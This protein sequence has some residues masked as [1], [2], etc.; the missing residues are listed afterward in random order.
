MRSVMSKTA[1]LR[2]IFTQR[3]AAR[4]R[5]AALMMILIV[6]MLAAGVVPAQAANG[7]HVVGGLTTVGGQAW[8]P[9]PGGA[10]DGNL[11][12]A[13][14]VL[15]LCRVDLDTG[16][17]QFVVN[18]ATCNTAASVPGQFAYAPA[19]NFLYVPAG[20]AGSASIVR[21]L[22]DP[23][24]ETVGTPVAISTAPGV[25]PVPDLR[26]AAVALGP[27]G[28]LY[29]SYLNSGAIVRIVA[30]GSASPTVQAVGTSS[31]GGGVRS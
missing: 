4:A 17:T 3:S 8:L 12:V 25:V 26:P 13:D 9:G 19:G 20:A 21:L 16:G 18:P 24:T 31:T 5:Q 30:P 23:T 28:S 6:S 10:V 11:W 1:K 29:V 15:G 22:Y 2:Q 14:R 7:T 27:S